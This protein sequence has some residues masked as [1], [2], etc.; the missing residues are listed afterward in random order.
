MPPE[1]STPGRG[2]RPPV[3]LPVVL[4]VLLSGCADIPSPLPEPVTRQGDRMFSLWRLSN[5]AGLLVA[6]LVWAL[7]AWCVLRYRRRGEGLPT[8]TA[9]N[10]PV[11][12]VYTAAPLLL[13]AALFAFTVAVQEDVTDTTGQPDLVVDVVGF[14]WQWRFEYPEHGVAVTGTPDEIPVLVLPV[15]R[16]VRLRLHAPDVVHSFFV[17]RFL[18]KL[19][20]VP[21]TD[22]ELDVDVE[23]PGEWVG[24][25]AEFCGIDHYKMNF[26]VRAVPL[27]EFE[28]WLASE[29]QR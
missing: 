6:L 1:Q 10:V 9:H 24:R 22:N 7:V 15:D 12:V 21:G 20:M 4:L 16:T 3:R 2:H 19:D 23:E 18:T 13:V 11:E 8:Q 28:A 17:P 14:Q 5:V 27:G 25:C 29:R 26:A